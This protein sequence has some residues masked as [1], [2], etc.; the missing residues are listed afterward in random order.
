MVR[1]RRVRAL[2]GAALVLACASV[3]V[4]WASGIGLVGKGEGI[5]AW[6]PPALRTD[7]S[8]P[9]ERLMIGAFGVA[10]WREPPE[11][12]VEK[13][14]PV[15]ALPAMTLLGVQRSGDAY[16]ALVRLDRTGEMA[17]VV[18]GDAFAGVEIVGVD[19]EGV[20]GVFDGREIR[21]RLGEVEP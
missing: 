7:E 19:S 2:S 8:V 14:R 16:R 1:I 13:P 5:V 11:V 18:G 4:V 10:L 3:C 20:V 6:E 17:R 21:L 9:D 15:R 12:V